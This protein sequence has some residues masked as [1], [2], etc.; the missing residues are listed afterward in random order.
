MSAV[1]I[2]AILD[3]PD[4]DVDPAVSLSISCVNGTRQ[5]SCDASHRR[6]W[7]PTFAVAAI[8][9]RTP[10]ARTRRGIPIGLLRV[11]DNPIG[12]A[13][14]TFRETIKQFEIFARV[15]WS[16]DDASIRSDTRLRVLDSAA[17]RAGGSA[18]QRKTRTSLCLPA[19]RDPRFAIEWFGCYVARGTGVGFY[20]VLQGSAGFSKVL[21]VLQ[22]LVV[23][24]GSAGSPGFCGFSKVLRML[25]NPAR[26][27]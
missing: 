4:A 22:V 5:F 27:Q 23:L 1:T 11:T 10:D 17:A 12:E 21:R 16:P 20:S 9:S 6:S 8:S 18:T 25:P 14:P 15:L 26:T 19:V 2:A 24:Q 13:Q 7:A 3:E